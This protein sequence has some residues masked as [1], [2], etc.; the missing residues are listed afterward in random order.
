LPAPACSSIR[1]GIAIDCLVHE[2]ASIAEL[3]LSAKAFDAHTSELVSFV[4]SGLAG[5]WQVD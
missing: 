3:Q 4:V 2:L 1:W 5:Q